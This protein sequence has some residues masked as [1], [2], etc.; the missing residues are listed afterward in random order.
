MVLR[1][2]EMMNLILR[3]LLTNLGRY[4]IFRVKLLS[5]NLCF[6][7]VPKSPDFSHIRP[8]AITEDVYCGIHQKP[9]RYSESKQNS[10]IAPF[11]TRIDVQCRNVLLLSETKK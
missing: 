3:L 4:Y 9:V 5:Q 6:D 1:K 11:L 2:A 10:K 8:S 7:S